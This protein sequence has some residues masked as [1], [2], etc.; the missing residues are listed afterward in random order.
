VVVSGPSGVL[1]P[2]SPVP[3]VSSVD[4]DGDGFPDSV[5]CAPHDQS[6]HPGASDVPDVGLVD[7]NCDGIDGDAADAVFVSPAGDDANPGT[8]SLPLRTLG[9]AVTAA[10][11]QRK[12]VYAAIGTYAEELR[13]VSGVSVYGGYSPV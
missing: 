5:D 6:I 2:P 7:S 12:D 9:A 10:G 4:G 3:P 1:S 11:G 8:M 13:V